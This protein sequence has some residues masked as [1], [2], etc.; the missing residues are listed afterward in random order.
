MAAVEARRLRGR[1][2]IVTG[3]GQGVGL[4]IARRF[5]AEGAALL[6]AQRNAAVG[7]AAVAAIRAD[8]GATAEFMTVDVTDREQ[9]Y[10]MVEKAVSRF[11]KL[12]IL[13]NNAGGSRPMRLEQHSD[14]DLAW[15]LDLN[16]WSSFWGMNAAFPHMKRQKWGRIIN[17]GSLN[18]V[19]AHP[20]TAQYNIAKEAVRALTRTAAV[21]WAEHGICCNV[22][23]PSAASPAGEEYMRNNPEMMKA[24]E[25]QIPFKRMGNAED[26]IGPVAAF[27]AGEDSR[28][29]TGMTFFA[30]GGSHMNGVHFRPA[31]DD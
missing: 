10:A 17:L 19:N 25:S 31:V 5:A 11:G 20:Y 18:G 13:V 16:L 12:D 7:E 15:G 26:D 21:E 6:L 3:G 27:L 29:L 23:C 22:I 4:G 30:D 8:F 9:V 1:V 2:A 28:F 24:V 14:A